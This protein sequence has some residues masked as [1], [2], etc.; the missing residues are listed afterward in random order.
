[1]SPLSRD[2]FRGALLS[3]KTRRAEKEC[4]VAKGDF[5]I[6]S[7][8]A[9]AEHLF[10]AGERPTAI[11]CFNDEIAIGVIETA[12]HGG[13]NI[14]RDLSVIGFDDIRFARSVR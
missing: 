5:S 13:L 4:L 8:V 11:F 1:V 2:R 6:E 7:G 3:A 14:P 9:A 12:K 10:G